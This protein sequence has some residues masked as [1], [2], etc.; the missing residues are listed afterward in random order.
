M[1]ER[2]L[3]VRPLCHGGLILACVTTPR[4]VRYWRSPT[5]MG[6]NYGQKVFLRGSADVALRA[7]LPNLEPS[8]DGSR[9]SDG[10][11]P[12]RRR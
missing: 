7:R 8:L 9:L 6:W 4:Q 3:S 12:N 1:R 10:C 2:S 5:A 11:V